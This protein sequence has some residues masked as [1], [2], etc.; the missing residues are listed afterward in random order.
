MSKILEAGLPQ[1]DMTDIVSYC[2]SL[3]RL[4]TWSREATIQTDWASAS[5]TFWGHKKFPS[6]ADPERFPKPTATAYAWDEL[7]RVITRGDQQ[8][9]ENGVLSFFKIEST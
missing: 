6:F 3:N 9:D 7:G 4:L 2:H 1:P 5:Q 8:P